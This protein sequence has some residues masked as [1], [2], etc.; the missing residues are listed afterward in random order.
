[1]TEAFASTS[2]LQLVCSAEMKGSGVN[3][4]VSSEQAGFWDCMFQ[5]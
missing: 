3:C 2:M 5:R 4:R 1:M